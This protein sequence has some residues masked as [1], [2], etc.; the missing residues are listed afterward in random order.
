VEGFEDK[1]SSARW[2]VPPGWRYRLFEDKNACGGG[3]RDLTGSGEED[4]F[5]DVGFGDDVSCSRWIS[6]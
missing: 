2:C 4:D 6:P 3:V 5:N 1:A